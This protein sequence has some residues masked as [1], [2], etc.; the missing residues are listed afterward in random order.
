MKDNI[1]LLHGSADNLKD[2]ISSKD[3]YDYIISVDSAYHYNTRWSF[4]ESAYVHLKQQGGMIGLYDLTIDP[5]FKNTASASQKQMIKFI[6]D[7]LSIPLKNL[8][9]PEEYQTHLESIGYKKVQIQ[10]LDRKRIFGGLSAA[11][12]KQYATAV[13]NG[14]GISIKN[15]IVLKVSSYLFGMLAEKPYIVP[16]LVQGTKE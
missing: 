10:Q 6:C 9:T 13:K 12:K 1:S 2:L 8:V 16:V 14:I 11:F 7:A 15:T 3:I 4:L 5:S